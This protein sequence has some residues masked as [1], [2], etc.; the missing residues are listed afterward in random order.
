MPRDGAM[1]NLAE[2]ILQDQRRLAGE[3]G[4]WEAHWQSV[5]DLCCPR[6][7]DF[8]TRRS[9]GE[10]RTNRQFDSTA[11]LA[12]ENFASANMGMIVPRYLSGVARPEGLQNAG[13]LETAA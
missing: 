2:E 13:A 9:P 7:A 11:A 1:T 3:R 12:A 8:Q 5:A 10:Q 6:L 4:T